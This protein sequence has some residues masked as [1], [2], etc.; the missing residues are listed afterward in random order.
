MFYTVCSYTK[1]ETFQFVYLEKKKKTHIYYYYFML[2]KLS[3]NHNMNFMIEMNVSNMFVI[4]NILRFNCD[5][6]I[7]S[8]NFENGNNGKRNVILC[9]YFIKIA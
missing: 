5:E 4:L 7:D 3:F 6:V 8:E 2:L 9:I 1:C